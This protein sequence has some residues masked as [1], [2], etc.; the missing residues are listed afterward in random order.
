MTSDQTAV[1]ALRGVVGFERDGSPGTLTV[2]EGDAGG[3]V[4]LNVYYRENGAAVI[5]DVH[6]EAEVREGWLKQI[7]PASAPRSAQAAAIAATLAE[8]AAVPGQ[9]SVRME[10]REAAIA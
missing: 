9:H 4:R 8:I 7:A 3:F 2:T 6:L 10:M 1:G 5:R